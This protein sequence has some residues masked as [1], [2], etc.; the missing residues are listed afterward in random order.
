MAKTFLV[1]GTPGAGKSTVLSGLRGAETVNIG[2]ELMK[3]LAKQLGVTDRDLMRRVAVLDNADMVKARRSVFAR[4]SRKKATLMVDTHASVKSGGSFVPGMS[5]GDL[6]LLR[7][8]V[9]AIFYIDANTNDILRRRQKDNTRKRDKD[10]AEE[11][12]T[13]RSLNMAFAAIYSM[14]LEVP[15]YLIKNETGRLAKAQAEV[16]KTVASFK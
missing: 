1:F 14:Y 9:K 3:S 16:R 5:Y 7:N 8:R 13:H 11:L 12:D 6:K 2:S 10:S 15:I 4:L